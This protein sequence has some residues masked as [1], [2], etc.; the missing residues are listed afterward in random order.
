MAKFTVKAS[1]PEAHPKEPGKPVVTATTVT[2]QQEIAHAALQHIIKGLSQ[3]IRDKYDGHADWT[4]HLEH[5]A[6]NLSLKFSRRNDRKLLERSWRIPDDSIGNASY[7]KGL[8]YNIADAWISML[9]NDEFANSLAKTKV[10]IQPV[11]FDKEW[12]VKKPDAKKKVC[13]LCG[14]EDP[15]YPPWEGGCPHKELK[16]K[17]Y[18]K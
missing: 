13:K 5:L 10:E 7:R 14:P 1:E 6:H 2:W 18:F 3:E 12:D 17:R 8:A 4:Y 15:Y 9:M 16:K 11:V